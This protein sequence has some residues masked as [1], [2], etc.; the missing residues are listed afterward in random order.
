MSKFNEKKVA[1][2]AEK[3]VNLAGGE[4]YKESN[5]LELVSILLTS[6][7]QNSFYET[8]EQTNNRLIDLIGKTQPDFVAKSALYARNEFGMRSISHITAA[9]LA[10]YLSNLPWAKN[11]YNKIVRRPDDMM[12]ILAYYMK[13]KDNK[14][15][16][17]MK[18]GFAEAISRFDAYQ[19]GKWRGEGKDFKL[20]DIANLVHPVPTQGDKF[21]VTVN[22]QEYIDILNK[23]LSLKKKAEDKKEIEKKLNWVKS[24]E[25]G[26]I[27][28]HALEALV[29]D[30]LRSKDTWESELSKAGQIANNEDEKQDLK[31]DAW[32]KLLSERKI[33]YFALLRNLRN[34]VEQ[35]P[36]MIDVACELLTDEKLIKKSLVLP[37]R[38]L[39]AYKE[40]QSLGTSDS[41]YRKVLTAINEATEI[42]LNN[43]P[44]FDG[45]TLVVLDTSG[46]MTSNKVAK[47][48]ISCA[49]AGAQFAAAIA[50]RNGCD[51][52][53][54]DDHAEYKNYNPSDSLMTI[55]NIYKFA[56]AGTNF[57]SIFQK[58]NKAYDR[59]IIL[60]D[61]QGWVGYHA[62][63]TTFKEY[64]KKYK[65]QSHIYSIDL[66][67]YGTLQFP[68]NKVYALAGFSDKVFD[69]MKMLEQDRQAL[70]HKIEAVEI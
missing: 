1:Y 23:K 13:K 8:E 65:C 16:N 29:I 63:T 5:K 50:K 36:E 53:R 32:T 9:E 31:K 24:Q 34:I 49:E 64:C 25:G 38:F 69:L 21:L 48:T 57:H 20:V 67:G 56:C 68:E 52:M 55:T 30:L 51:L 62:P 37:F 7:V 45:E 47:S 70:I 41:K 54:F 27:K 19:L 59:I 42:S 58:A 11:F 26:T 43:I 4:A 60:S 3:T 12:E 33:G 22:R 66:K 44:K 46:S 18:K 2:K 10:K 40:L 61:E 15:T 35:A 17:S 39:V 6:F 28:I 14:I